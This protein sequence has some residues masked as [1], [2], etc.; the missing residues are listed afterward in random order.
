MS[1]VRV[2]SP[3]PHDALQVDQGAHCDSLQ[4]SGSGLEG[5]VGGEVGGFV[6]FAFGDG[7]SGRVSPRSNFLEPGWTECLVIAI[8]EACCNWL[9][10]ASPRPAHRP[11]LLVPFDD[12]RGSKDHEGHVATTTSVMNIARRRAG[13]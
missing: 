5:G 2:F 8:A 6:F 12:E 13:R 4:S 11:L 3:T 7:V 10:D 1:R 9:G